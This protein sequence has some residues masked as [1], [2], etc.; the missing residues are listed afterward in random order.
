MDLSSNKYALVVYTACCEILDY[1]SAVT[2][3]QVQAGMRIGDDIGKNVE[4]EADRI[5]I[6]FAKEDSATVE[7]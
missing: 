2:C 7:R 3:L 4:G 5:L 6:G 1:K